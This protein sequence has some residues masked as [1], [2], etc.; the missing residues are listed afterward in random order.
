M[1]SIRQPALALHSCDVPGFQYQMQTTWA[2][3]SGATATDVVYWIRHAVEHAPE[4][5]LANVVI[6]CHGGPG[7]L[8]VGGTTSQPIAVGAVGL[9][10]QLRTKDI[11]TLWL[12]GC[13]VATGANGQHFCSQLAR[14]MGCFV[15]AANDTQF[16][17]RRYYRGNCPFGSIDDFEGTAYTFSPSGS[18]ELFS[19]HD[20]HAETELYK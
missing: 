8:F 17:E 15:V 5:A 18:K 20:P 16:V 10:G 1:I 3:P 13:L 7:K 19:I 2:M 14:T 9:F 4:L 11:G 12:V 6:N